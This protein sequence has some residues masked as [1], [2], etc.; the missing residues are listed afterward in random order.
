MLKNKNKTEL[1]LEKVCQD[2]NNT[3]MRIIDSPDGNNVY[4]YKTMQDVCSLLCERKD[5][6]KNSYI[7]LI[8]YKKLLCVL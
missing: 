4:I 2:S 1:R 8:H 5:D 6:K 7:V 3:F